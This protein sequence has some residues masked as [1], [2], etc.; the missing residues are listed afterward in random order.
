MGDRSVVKIPS[1]AQLDRFTE[2]LVAHVPLAG[3]TLGLCGPLGVGKTTFVRSLATKLGVDSRH[4]SS[5]TYVLQNQYQGEGIVIDHWDLYRV[6]SVPLEL[7]IEPE[8]NCLRLIEW[9]D[10][11][12]MINDMTLTMEF[13]K[14]NE[15]GMGEE[16]IITLVAKNYSFDVFDNF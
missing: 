16:R 7:S 3:L 15:L 14:S 10:K 8:L 4:I 9:A 12:E 1:L 6:G 13:C 2:E 11:F 5:P